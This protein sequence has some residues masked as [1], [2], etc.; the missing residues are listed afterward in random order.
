MERKYWKIF[1]VVQVIG[2]LAGFEALLLQAPLL[3]GVSMLYLLPGSLASFALSKAGH[4]GANWSMW[5]LGAI[6]VT[7]N[8]MV[9]TLASY[10]RTRL[11]S[12]T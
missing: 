2:G 10:L 6:A 8:V 1:G 3:L 4:V 7:T 5:T 11:R 9:F 12:S